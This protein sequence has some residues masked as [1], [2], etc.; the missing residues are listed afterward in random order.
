MTSHFREGQSFPTNYVLDKRIFENDSHESWVATQSQTGDRVFIKLLTNPITDAEWQFVTQSINDLKGLVHE[1]IT[2]VSETGIEDDVH[3]TIEPYLASS[4]SFAVETEDPWPVLKQ[5]INALRYAHNLGIAHGNLHPGN[6]TVDQTGAVHITGYGL[7][8]I[9]SSITKDS[10]YFNQRFNKATPADT[11][12][13]IYALGCL[14]FH[15]L[16]GKQ[17]QPD[18]ETNVPLSPDIEVLLNRMLSDST[19]ERDVDLQ[20]VIDALS[21]HFEPATDSIQS[22]VF[23]RQTDTSARQAPSIP[24]AASRQTQAIGLQTVIGAAI[25]LVVF[26]ALLF[27]FL[28]TEPDRADATTPAKAIVTPPTSLSTSPPDTPSITP[29]EAAKLAHMQQEGQRLAKEILRHQIDLE[30]QGV[31]LWATEEYSQVTNALDEA[32][33]IYRQSDFESVFNHYEQVL[34]S[35]QGLKGQI[36]IVLEQQITLGDAAL[37]IGDSKAAIIAF[38]IATTIER[39]NQQLSRKLGRAENLEEVIDLM[40]RGEVFEKNGDLDDAFAVFQQAHTIDELWQP[41]SIAIKRSRAAIKQREFQVAMSEAFQAITIKD[42]GQARAGFV[43]AQKILPTS[44]EPADGLLQVEQSERNDAIVAHRLKAQGHL[45]EDDW[46]EAI[47]DF[48]AALAI[49]STLEFALEGLALAEHRLDLRQRLQ[50]YLRDPTLL[51]DNDDLKRASQTLRDATKV[52]PKSEQILSYID[53][54]AKL[55]STARI[56]LPV[57]ISSDGKTHITVRKHAAL[58]KVT[59]QTVYLIPGRYTIVGE[60]SGFR[61]VREDLIIIAGRPIPEVTIASTERIR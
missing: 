9:Y 18:V 45:A 33:N 57:T 61:D 16:T 60:R 42:Y 4:R 59:E 41:A 26:A 48:K 51:Q 31:F 14:I 21:R 38:T 29:L 46:N 19:F 53:T 7:P 17:W 39:A 8:A 11:T 52:E 58:G 44:T 32:D 15:A 30:D 12:D 1:N 43:A 54:L 55:I 27:F 49:T 50:D 2:L 20:E 10:P 25:A 5:I 3:Y 6:L 35:L 37:E 34:S 56:K 28:P 13:D 47:V 36:P 22:V 40:K 24:V 23:S